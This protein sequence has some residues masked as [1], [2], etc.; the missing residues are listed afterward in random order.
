MQ[1]WTINNDRL[2]NLGEVQYLGVPYEMIKNGE[3]PTLPKDYDGWFPFMRMCYS[4]GDLG[5]VSGVFEALKQKYPNIMIAFPSKEY[6][7]HILGPSAI[8]KWGFDENN[9][10]TSNLDT[11][12]INNPF[13]DKI[14][15]VG[16][17]TKVFIDHDRSYTKLV[18]DGNKVVSCDEPL[19]EQ[20]LRRWG[21]NDDDIKNIDSTP[22][23]YFTQKEID[24]CENIINQHIGS[25]DYGCLLLASRLKEYANR[26]WDGEEYLFQY[27]EKYKDLPIFYYSQNQLENTKWEEF[28]PNRIDFSQLGLSIREQIYIKRKAKFNVGYQAG[29]TDIS[30][31]GG[32]DIITLCPYNS[33]RENCIRGTRYV[34][35]DGSTKIIEK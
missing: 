7:N 32:S 8:E 16:E 3:V 12:L 6:I 4:I 11:I 14:F 1:Q 25:Y 30:S 28:F 17:F 24:K 19:A 21:F 2:H 9:T 20:I 31:G 13:I 33:I 29:I 10:G 35:T 34:Y 23:L 26:V 15:N 5:I 18:H 22:K 27:I